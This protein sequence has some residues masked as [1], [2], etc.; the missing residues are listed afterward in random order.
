MPD[1]DSP[2]NP[3]TF[4]PIAQ[5]HAKPSHWEAAAAATL[6]EVKDQR[7]RGFRLE[8]PCRFQ[9]PL[10]LP[11][12]P[13]GGDREPELTAWTAPP[14][15]EPSSAARTTPSSRPGPPSPRPAGFGHSLPTR[16][17]PAPACQGP[18]LS[19][20]TQPHLASAGK[21]PCTASLSKTT[22]G[23]VSHSPPLRALRGGF[24]DPMLVLLLKQVRETWIF[25]G[26]ADSDFRGG[27]F[28]VF[29]I[30]VPLTQLREPAV[31]HELKVVKANGLYPKRRRE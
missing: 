27:F 18:A 23:P 12:S 14:L 29:I 22:P 25:S 6:A 20:R 11:P 31:V 7:H 13:R 16:L 15:H 10:W 17:S 28:A 3:A 24:G 8:C 19:S 2:A 26:R 1:A 21:A 9:R 5:V 30:N 4:V